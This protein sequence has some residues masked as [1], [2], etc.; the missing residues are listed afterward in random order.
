MEEITQ[1][2]IVIERAN[3][4]SKLQQPQVYIP[5]VTSIVYECEIYA[6]VMRRAHPEYAIWS[7][8]ATLGCK[9]MITKKIINFLY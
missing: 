9:Y 7:L 8:P 1:S 4:I 6:D 3:I 5:R 2:L